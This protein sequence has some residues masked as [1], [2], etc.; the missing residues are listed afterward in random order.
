MRVGSTLLE[1]GPLDCESK[2]DISQILW[3]YQM[4]TSTGDL[5]F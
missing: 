1:L 3:T 4:G 5:S 2:K